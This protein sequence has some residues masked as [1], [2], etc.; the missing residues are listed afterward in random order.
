MLVL[1]SADTAVLTL[2][3]LNGIRTQEILQEQGDDRNHGRSDTH[4]ILRVG[5]VEKG[6]M[7]LEG[8]MV[9]AMDSSKGYWLVVII[10]ASMCTRLFKRLLGSGNYNHTGQYVQWALQ[11]VTG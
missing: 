7:I 1:W 10:R 8:S 4:R 5:E 2:R 9:C 3:G 11:K 6:T